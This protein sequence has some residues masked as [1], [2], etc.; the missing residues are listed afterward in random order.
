M[1]FHNRVKA[2]RLNREVERKL[3]ELF[4]WNEEAESESQIIRGL[5][6]KEWRKI[7]KERGININGKGDGRIIS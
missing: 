3:L 5:I 4:K 6:L 2:F 1:A 7:A